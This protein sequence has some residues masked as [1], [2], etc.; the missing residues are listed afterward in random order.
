MCWRETCRESRLDAVQPQVFVLNYTISICT[1]CLQCKHAFACIRREYY[2]DMGMICAVHILVMSSPLFFSMES[3]EHNGS[4]VQPILP[5]LCVTV[6]CVYEVT[7]IPAHIFWHKVS[8]RIFVWHVCPKP[9]GVCW[10]LQYWLP[11][12]IRHHWRCVFWLR[13]PAFRALVTITK[14]INLLSKSVPSVIINAKMCVAYARYLWSTFVLINVY[15]IVAISANAFSIEHQDNYGRPN[16]LQ[17]ITLDLC[18]NGCSWEPPSL[19][20]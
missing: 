1:N 14:V 16:T 17:S 18:R 19:C 11:L 5:M 3:E 20:S 4:N 7:G 10:S 6:C 8:N 15:I 2:Q 12:R 9:C 13:P